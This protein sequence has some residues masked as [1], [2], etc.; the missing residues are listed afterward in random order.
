MSE[1]EILN[2]TEELTDTVEPEVCDS[3]PTNEDL[4]S[5]L[6]A[7]NEKFDS[8]IQN[9]EWKNQKY[10]EMHGLMLKYQDDLLSKTVDPILKSLL[11]LCDSI[12]KDIKLCRNDSNDEL[13][14]ILI[15]ITEQIE[16]ILFDYDVEPYTAG[17]DAVNTKEQKVAK[18]VATKDKDKDN[19][20]AE[21][22][23]T[24]YKKNEKIFRMEKVAIYKYINTEDD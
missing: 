4:L 19:C 6:N 23:A 18:T 11:R 5:S 3:E 7:L 16:A 14:D 1:Q 13:C 15:G 9:D 20:V 22:I 2:A 12:G 8:K 24:G 21:I 17:F 10:D